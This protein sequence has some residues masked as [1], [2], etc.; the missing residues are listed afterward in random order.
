MW[1]AVHV[2]LDPDP[3]ATAIARQVVEDACR[4]WRLDHVQD[5]AQLVITELVSNVVRHAGTKMEISLAA[6]PGV[7]RLAV[8]D[9]SPT[10]PRPDMSGVTLAENG[11]GLVVI[12]ALAIE[13]GATPSGGGKV[14]WAVLSTSV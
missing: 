6:S 2:E 3:S 13:W 14:V 8:R 12:Q 9:G 1:D 7:L 10:S 11:R 4:A 5:A